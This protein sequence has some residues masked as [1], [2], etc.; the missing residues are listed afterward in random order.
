MG[1]IASRISWGGA[2]VVPGVRRVRPRLLG[3]RFGGVGGLTKDGD[4]ID[5]KASPFGSGSGR[6]V[7]EEAFA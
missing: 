2:L 4:P 6:L 5:D 3:F 7:V 1:G